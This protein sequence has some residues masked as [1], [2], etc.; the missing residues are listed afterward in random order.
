[1]PDGLYAMKVALRVLSALSGKHPPDTGDVV[2]LRRLTPGKDDIPLDELACEVIQLTLR[3]RQ[4]KASRSG[5][6]IRT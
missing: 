2:D 6:V 1:M 5:S 4:T 3:A